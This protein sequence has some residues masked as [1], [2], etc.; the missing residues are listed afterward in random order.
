[1]DNDKEL[2]L[3]EVMSNKIGAIYPKEKSLEDLVMY[4]QGAKTYRIE[5]IPDDQKEVKILLNIDVFQWH[6]VVLTLFFF[7]YLYNPHF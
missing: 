5:I 4:G 1:M 7:H 2:R 6:E 3:L